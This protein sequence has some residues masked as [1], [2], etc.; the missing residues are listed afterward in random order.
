MHQPA[1]IDRDLREWRAG[2]AE[3]AALRHRFGCI[4]D[5]SCPKQERT[6]RGPITSAPTTRVRAPRADPSR[7]TPWTAQASWFG[8][9]GEMVWGE[10]RTLDHQGCGDPDELGEGAVDGVA[11]RSPLGAELVPPWP[12]GA[13]AD[14]WE[15]LAWA[16]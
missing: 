6:R 13:A 11:A 4:D 9:R 10:F 1:Q 12:A 5:G 15:D 2:R 7:S 8:Q 14:A 16:G 3:A